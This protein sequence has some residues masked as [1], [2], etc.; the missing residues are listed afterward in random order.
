MNTVLSYSPVFPGC[1][2]LNGSS[3]SPQK[4]HEFRPGSKMKPLCSRIRL[5]GRAYVQRLIIMNRAM[6][7]SPEVTNRL[8]TPQASSLDFLRECSS[9]CLSS[10]RG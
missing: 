9:P 5:P 8:A 1:L 3:T 10:C 7:A 6:L 4:L 2:R